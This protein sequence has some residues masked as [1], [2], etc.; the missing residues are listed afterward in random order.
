MYFVFTH[1]DPIT[2]S[3]LSY[4]ADHAPCTNLGLRLTADTQYLTGDIHMDAP[5]MRCVLID[6]YTG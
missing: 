1:R 2:H 6:P 4:I 5:P 3:Q